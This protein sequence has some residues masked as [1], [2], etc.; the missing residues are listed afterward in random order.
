MSELNTIQH[1]TAVGNELIDAIE[2][3]PKVNKSKLISKLKKAIHTI[4]H[5]PTLPIHIISLP[6]LEGALAQIEVDSNSN[7]FTRTLAVAITNDPT[8]LYVF[9][10]KPRTHLRKTRR[11]TPGTLP[12][13]ITQAAPEQ[14]SQWLNPDKFIVEEQ[15]LVKPNSYRIPFNIQNCVSQ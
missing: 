11:N 12:K 1:A 15:T 2:T 4:E 8:V 10:E 5:N 7:H 13:I 14:L 6:I 3:I 9:I